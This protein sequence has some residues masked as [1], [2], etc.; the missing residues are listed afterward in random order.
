MSQ[1]VQVAGSLLVL[2]GFLGAQRG[3]FD[4]RSRTYLVVNAVGSTTLAL[5]AIVDRQWG[6]LLL[7]GVWAVVSA[8]GLV[9]A[10]RARRPSR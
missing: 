8:T 1:V 6:F 5:A 3:W 10:L 7:E 4:Q 2:F 9:A